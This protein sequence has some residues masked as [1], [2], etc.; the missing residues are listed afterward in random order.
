MNKR[1]G[2][3]IQHV[4]AVI[5]GEAEIVWR[6]VLEDVQTGRLKQLYEGGFVPMEDIPPARHDLLPG[7]Y[8]VGSI[9]TTRGCPLACTFCSVT[10]FNGRECRHRPI[11]N[12]IRELRLITEKI[13][14]FVDDNLIGTRKDHV[15]Y[16]KARFREM[17][18][19]GLTTPWFCQATINFADDPEL[20]EL[21]ERAGC[22][23]V[24]IGFESPTVEGLLEVRKKFNMIKGRDL[25]ASVRRIQAAGIL[26]TGSFIMGL[27]SDQPGIGK[28]IAEAADV[29]GVDMANVLILTPLPGTMLWN[30]MR[31]A[32]RITADDFPRDWQYYTLSYPVA[33][34][35]NFTW[36]D[37]VQEMNQFN[38]MFYGYP[39][40]I[41]RVLR[42]LRYTRKPRVLLVSAAGNLTYRSNH[43]TDRNVYDGRVEPAGKTRHAPGHP[44]RSQGSSGSP[45][46]TA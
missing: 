22:V 38:D 12:V 11:A 36:S 6:Q 10:A 42:M 18:R 1:E 13:I 27:D 34:Y 44:A 23:G 7:Q 33:K 16:C 35:A 24:F 41:H 39:K 45:G 46:R 28:L 2:Q 21:A 3:A 19:E 25:P 32:G 14:L 37:L 17:I 29:Y 15:E 30:E 31:A 4:D 20:L 26:V 43:L 8:Y 9:Q 40:I 5:T